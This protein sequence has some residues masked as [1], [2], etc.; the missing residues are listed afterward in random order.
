MKII[1]YILIITSCSRLF[2]SSSTI[3]ISESEINLEVYLAMPTASCDNN[4]CY[5]PK[6][7]YFI[8]DSTIVCPEQT[9]KLA[10]KDKFGLYRVASLATDSHNSL[11]TNVEENCWKKK[12]DETKSKEKPQYMNPT[13]SSENKRVKSTSSINSKKA[14]TDSTENLTKILYQD[15]SRANNNDEA[16]KSFHITS[17]D[18]DYLNHD[19][20]QN[21]FDDKGDIIY[22]SSLILSLLSFIGTL[23]KLILSSRGNKKAHEVDLEKALDNLNTLTKM[24]EKK[25]TT[26]TARS[27]EKKGAIGN[28]RTTN[29]NKNHI[30]HY[31]DYCLCKKGNCISGNCSCFKSNK[32]CN[33]KCHGVLNKNCK[34]RSVCIDIS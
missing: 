10:Y 22:G 21:M 28:T 27:L 18:I 12:T 8:Q 5:Y 26:F 11:N 9:M 4:G 14:N 19:F 34:A 16:A 13:F 25:S 24:T 7:F 3:Y 30:N 15:I 2:I 33:E 20:P 29:E 1:L 31:K 17:E 6:K 23:I 32:A